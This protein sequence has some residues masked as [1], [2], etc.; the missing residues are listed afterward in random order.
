MA[1]NDI[2]SHQ[3]TTPEVHELPLF[4]IADPL[5]YMSNTQRRD[6]AA[7]QADFYYYGRDDFAD[8]LTLE[9]GRAI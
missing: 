2:A 8:G 6:F 1:P 4:G 5:D 9:I 3:I 7:M